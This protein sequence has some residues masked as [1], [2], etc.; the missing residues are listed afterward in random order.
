MNT[1]LPCLPKWGLRFANR[2]RDLP[3]PQ[4]MKPKAKTLHFT[5]PSKPLEFH[6]ERLHLHQ[7]N[8]ESQNEVRLTGQKFRKELL[9]GS[10]FY[11]EV[12][13]SGWRTR[14]QRMMR[15]RFCSQRVHVAKS[16]IL[17]PQRGCMGNALGLKYILYSY[18]DPLGLL[19][20]MSLGSPCCMER[21]S[22]DGAR[23][24]WCCSS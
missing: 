16:C 7:T 6:P 3:W 12:P 22:Q 13:R 17:S 10:M 5:L 2:S 9:S 20:R 19:Y 23:C 4:T 24:C 8:M 11:G 14:P 18:M 1:C 15:W 21:N